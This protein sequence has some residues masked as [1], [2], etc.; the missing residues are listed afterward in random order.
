MAATEHWEL[1]APES[2]CAS[3]YGHEALPIMEPT[4]Y[5]PTEVVCRNCGAKYR[6]VVLPITEETE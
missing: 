1:F 6:I 3:P 5:I 4:S 2:Q